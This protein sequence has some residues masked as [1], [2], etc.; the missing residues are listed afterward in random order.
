MNSRG[1]VSEKFPRVT[2]VPTKDNALEPASSHHVLCP[3]VPLT[4][5][6][7]IVWTRLPA[8][9]LWGY[10]SHPTTA[11][12]SGLRMESEQRGGE[13]NIWHVKAEG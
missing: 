5:Y 11:R 12:T 7:S 1:S 13:A 6:I 3:K 2:A 10:N 8:N 4:L 9:G